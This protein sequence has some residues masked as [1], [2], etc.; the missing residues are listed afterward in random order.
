[1]ILNNCSF[2]MNR[3][4][5][6]KIVNPG[7]GFILIA[8]VLFLIAGCQ[9][10]NTPESSIVINEVMPQNSSYVADQNGEYDD[11]IELHN[12]SSLSFDISGYYLSDKKS[13]L[14]MWKIPAGTTISGNGYLVFWIDKDSTQAGLHTNFKLSASGEKVLFITPDFLIIDEVEFPATPGGD[15][16][17]SRNPDGTGSF[18]W[19]TPTFNKSNN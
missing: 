9:K 1:M 11:W 12:N 2:L 6:K 17:Y 10:D 15:E 7:F 19:Q 4:K 16:S 8:S 3:F 14:S 18:I 5:S 13:D